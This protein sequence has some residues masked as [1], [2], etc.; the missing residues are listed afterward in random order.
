MIRELRA[1]NFAQKL[2]ILVY[3]PSLYE[4]LNPDLMIRECNEAGAD[5]VAPPDLDLVYA[6]ICRRFPTK[7]ASTANLDVISQCTQLI[8]EKKIDISTILQLTNT[9]VSDSRRRVALLKKVPSMERKDAPRNS[10]SDPYEKV[11]WLLLDLAKSEQECFTLQEEQFQRERAARARNRKKASHVAKL[12]KEMLIEYDAHEKD[13]EQDVAEKMLLLNK[14][15]VEKDSLIARLNEKATQI[16]FPPWWGGAQ[17]MQM[18]AEKHGGYLEIPLDPS[19]PLFQMMEVMMNC[20]P[21]VHKKVRHGLVNG[22]P[23]QSFVV[24]SVSRIVNVRLWT[25]YCHQVTLLLSRWADLPAELASKYLVKHPMIT[26]FLDAAT[27]EYWLF[28]GTAAG[29]VKILLQKGY[30]PRVCSVDGMFGGGFYFAENATKSN[31]YIPCPGCGQNAAFS[32]K[33][34]K[35]KNQESLEFDMIVYRACLGDV[36]VALEYDAK[37]YKGTARAPVRRA[38]QKADGFG[39]TY[40]CV[41]GER[42]ANLYNRE[43]VMYQG[44]QAYPEF[45]IKY[46]R[47]HEADVNQRRYTPANYYRHKF[48]PLYDKSATND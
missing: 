42:G 14:L 29:N 20:S 46:K 39:E 44:N 23:S 5:F 3:E 13:L 36:H 43:V 30:D 9:L 45:V 40:D 10:V 37:T 21:G 2:H 41:L 17:E 24:T 28:H 1:L 7:E 27:N 35:C 4:N 32:P 15:K 48:L 26:P 12:A 19:H 33:P 22:L 16:P 47:R 11:A 6:E 34:C 8:S 31:S 18:V 38:P 25:E